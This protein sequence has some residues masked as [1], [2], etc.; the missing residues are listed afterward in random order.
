MESFIVRVWVPGDDEHEVTPGLRGQV[1]HL[2]T[3]STRTFRNPQELLAS[4]LEA[5]EARVPSPPLE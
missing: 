1:Q 5:L 2:A 3:G 4:I